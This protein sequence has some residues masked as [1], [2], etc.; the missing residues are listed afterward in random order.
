MQPVGMSR[1]SVAHSDFVESRDFSGSLIR[2]WY[3]R[4]LRSGPICY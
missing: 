3:P 2:K 4:V 1:L